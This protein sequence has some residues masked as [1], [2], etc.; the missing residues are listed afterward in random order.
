MR[1]S[2]R[3]SILPAALALGAAS[4]Q[5]ADHA[6]IWGGVHIY[7]GSGQDVAG[8]GSQYIPCS[9]TACSVR[10]AVG[11]RDYNRFVKWCGAAKKDVIVTVGAMGGHA[12]CQGPTPWLLQVNVAM[13]NAQDV[14]TAHAE[15]VT[16]TVEATE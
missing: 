7:H 2:L 16:I 4:S 3:P 6:M 5:P 9:A 14:L 1:R 11:K 12:E 10:V 8:Y 13:H 15:P